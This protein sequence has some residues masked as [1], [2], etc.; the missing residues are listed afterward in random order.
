MSRSTKS[1][2]I[3]RASRDPGGF[4]AIPW[5][6]LDSPRYRGL[7]HP[8]R[9]LLVELA[10]QLRGDNNGMLLCSREYMG[11]RGWSWDV[12]H[13]AKQHLL[14]AGFLHETVKGHRP[15]K[16]SWYA[17]TWS[18]LDK[19]D[20]YD[21]GAAET[22]IRGAYKAPALTAAKPTRDELFAKW[23]TD[24]AE[25]RILPESAPPKNTALGPGGGPES[26]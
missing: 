1:K 7:S 14:A 8:A 24:K 5:S 6:V 15:N 12:V 10:R 25:A 20:G 3:A 22:F 26:R 4:V 9:A 21:A 23:R 11:K 13:R 16:A 18:A 19:I 2:Q 17:V